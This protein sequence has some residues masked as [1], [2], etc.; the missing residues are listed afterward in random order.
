M[1]G[2]NITA[3]TDNHVSQERLR[4]AMNKS[5]TSTAYSSK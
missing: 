5:P 2:Q 4:T 3:T 1:S